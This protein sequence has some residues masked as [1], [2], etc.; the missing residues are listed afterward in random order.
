MLHVKSN[1][2][3]MRLSGSMMA[4]A[5]DKPAARKHATTEATNTKLLPSEVSRL[6]LFE[7]TIDV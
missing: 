4:E 1:T 3:I 7:K 2:E 5:T 6:K